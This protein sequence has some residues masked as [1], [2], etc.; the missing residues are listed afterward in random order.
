LATIA[1]ISGIFLGLYFNAT[2][3]IVSNYLL[4]APQCVRRFLID[5]LAGQ[6][7]I[8]TV[9]MTGVISICYF[10]YNMLGFTIYPLILL[11][12]LLLT[13]YIIVMFWQ[14]GTNI[15]YY[16]EPGYAFPKIINTIN[17]SIENI[18]PPGFQ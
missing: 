4:E 12:L 2:S 16:L 17:G 6:Q 3:S 8:Q 15:F 14:I 5:N 1:S 13:I 18:A 11:F 10:F 7:Y 9:A